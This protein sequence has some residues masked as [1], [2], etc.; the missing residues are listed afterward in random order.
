MKNTLLPAL[1]LGFSRLLYDTVTI[2]TSA[3]KAWAY[4]RDMEN[5]PQW[6]VGIVKMQSADA[7]PLATVGKVY[8]EIGLAPGGKEENIT[9]H[10]IASSE[11]DRHLAI[12]ASL[13]PF[14]P[15]FDY[16]IVPLGAQ[17]CT[18]HWR[19]A[20]SNNPLALLASPI[21]RLILRSRLTKSL[22][23]IQRI[24][25]GQDSEIM[26]ASMFWRFGTAQ[27]SLQHF[28]RAARPVAG[29]GE[30]L[31]EQLASSINHIDCHRR[32]GYGRHVMRLKG[33][34]NYPIIL[35]NDIAG[36]VVAIGAGVSSL[37]V[38]DAVF[39]VKPPSSEGT[40][41]QFVSAKSIHVLQKPETV[42]FEQAAAL[43]YTFLTA[44]CALVRDCGLTEANASSSKVFIQGGAGGVGS[45]ALQIAKYL[46]AQVV[47]SCSASQKAQ[48]LAQGAAAA[49]DFKS[50]DYAQE[51][52]SFDIA[53]CTANANEQDKMIR[54]LKQGGRYA[55]VV[56]PTLALTDQL[57]LI[58]GLLSAK[59]Q[60]KMLN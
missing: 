23:N 55:T 54:I 56:H 45:M 59:K 26:Q 42:S 37:K 25:G 27:Q 57:G 34:L 21:F 58:K 16:K 47:V 22:A 2:N 46:G 30:V 15:R 1:G 28:T 36:C 51:G 60:L 11:A 41:A 39:G 17:Q 19:C 49:Y 50:E 33:A 7:L 53:L 6:F 20:V 43:P 14:V 38:G 52:A 12:R 3:D 32:A 31:I 9:V 48:V 10:V 4:L 29:K 44:Y 8:D 5:Y 40:F 24:L 13:K 35:G 18:L